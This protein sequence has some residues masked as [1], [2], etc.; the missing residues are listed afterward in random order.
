ML[1]VNP[2]LTAA[3]V[4]RIIKG[5]AQKVGGY[6]YAYSANHLNGTWHQEMGHGLV[7]AAA[8]VSAAQSLTND[9]YIKDNASDNGFE[10]NTST[11]AVNLSPSIK[12]LD[13]DGNEV[14]YPLANHTYTVR[15]TIHNN[16]SQNVFFNPSHLTIRWLAKNSNPLW[17]GSW[18]TA[19]TQC[20]VPLSGTINASGWQFFIT[21]PAGG[22]T[23]IS[24]TW[25]A[26]QI[27][28]NDCI[29]QYYETPLHIVA[30]V[31]DGGLTIGATATDYPLEQFV[32]T[33]NNVA[34]H[35]YTLVNDPVEPS[36]IT[37]IT[38]NPTSGEATVTCS[39]AARVTEATVIITDLMGNTVYTHNVTNVDSRCT[40]NTATLPTGQYLVQLL[41]ATDVLDTK[42]LVVSR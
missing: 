40:V 7:D 17:L 25:T 15:V 28:P 12:L 10:P 38:P 16:G 24:R 1:S 23:T 22:S 42:Q 19:G 11:A 36:L 8:A 18:T 20:G 4:A 27:L 13:A 26:P 31:N 34:W 5:T 21:I 33:N 32:R 41:S 30:V 2:N 3:Q 35:S 37:S 6:N 14:T 39:L 29:I 9:L